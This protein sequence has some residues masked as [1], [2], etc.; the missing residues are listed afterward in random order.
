M[1]YDWFPSETE[2]LGKRGGS[3]TSPETR[4]LPGHRL[5][6][7]STEF[8]RR[9]KSFNPPRDAWP[10]IDAQ[11]FLNASVSRSLSLPPF[12][13]LSLSLS[14]LFRPP[15][16]FLPSPADLAEIAHRGRISA[17]NLL[18]LQ[19]PVEARDTKSHSAPAQVH[20]RRGGRG[21]TRR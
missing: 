17:E 13:F 7:S 4:F 3:E 8:E 10:G 1:K 6:S 18:I 19:Q 21:V 11:L 20:K 16:P 14:S 15:S 12:S 2:A 9:V 5:S